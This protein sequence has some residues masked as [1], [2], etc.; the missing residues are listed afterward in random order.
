MKSRILSIF[1]IS[2]FAL[3]CSKEVERASLRPLVPTSNEP[4]AGT[5]KMYFGVATDY[6]V[7]APKE[8]SSAEYKAELAEA[9][10]VASNLTAE[11]KSALTY[12]QVGAVGR[13]N[14]I[15]RELIARYNLAPEPNENGSYSAPN[16]AKP[17]TLPYFPFANPPYASRAYALISVA[18]YDALVAT[19][20]YKYK[21][22]RKTNTDDLPDYPSEEAVIAAASSRVLKFLFPG[23]Y[24]TQLIDNKYEEGRKVG[25][26]AGK[27]VQSD[28]D[29]A[30]VLGKAVADKIIAYAKTDGT[31]TSG[32]NLTIQAQMAEAAVARGLKTAWKSLDIPARPGMLM[33]F[34]EVKTWN[35]DKATRDAIRPAAP[36][37]L[38]SDAFKKDLAEVKH[39]ADNITRK[40]WSIVQFWADGLGTSTPPGH[41]NQIAMDLIRDASMSEIRT[42]RA[43]ALMNTAIHDA[44]VCCWD[45]KYY[46]FYPRPNQ[47]DP[48]I[49]TATG[50]PNFPSYTS[51]HATFSAAAASVL[52]YIFPSQQSSLDAMAKEASESRIYG[53]IHY[54]FDSEVG[55]VCGK[56]IGD[57]AVARGKTDGGN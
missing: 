13:W 3:S 49:K 43:L 45:T 38:D 51:G 53:A 46:Y 36:P 12:W 20:A 26:W 21:Y 8:T 23:S 22:N 9:Q 16:S 54:R 14:E 1:F 5:W 35:F 17:D 50:T 18:Q 28:V 56:K 40:Q 39:Y 55:L 24:P 52:S 27:N 30:D 47:V 34:G 2:L 37:A 31:G 42:A 19:W 48:S 11:Q 32:G 25:I 29:A 15:A 44:G 41:W 7:P 10:K 4:N 6:T 33:K 57:Y